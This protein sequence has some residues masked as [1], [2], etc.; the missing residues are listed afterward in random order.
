MTANREATVGGALVGAPGH[1]ADDKPKTECG[2]WIGAERRHCREV[3]G[4]RP[5]ITG[6][7]CP[8]HTPRAL[9]G[10][11]EFPPGPGWPAHR[12]EPE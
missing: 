3:D 5:Y 10:L 11:D 12:K 8:A 4:I 2:H 7:R 9:R 6:P 1:P